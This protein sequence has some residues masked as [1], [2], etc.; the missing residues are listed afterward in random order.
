MMLATS[1]LR[2]S[3]RQFGQDLN[4]STNSM[5]NMLII[6]GVV[7]IIFGLI[8]SGKLGPLGLSLLTLFETH[9]TRRFD[10]LEGS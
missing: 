6:A 9:E 2:A 3:R 4:N 8:F 10:K 1:C 7:L 5:G